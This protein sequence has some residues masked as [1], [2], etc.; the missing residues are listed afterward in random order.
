M[1]VTKLR[2]DCCNK[3]ISIIDECY[4]IHYKRPMG[5]DIWLSFCSANC[6]HLAME[7]NILEAYTAMM[8]KIENNERKRSHKK[9]R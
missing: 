1:T 9:V 4:S 3:S 5:I 8:V 6:I 2:C 7:L